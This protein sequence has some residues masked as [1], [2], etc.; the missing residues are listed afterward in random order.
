[1]LKN[2]NQRIAIVLAVLSAFYLILSYQLPTYPYIPVDADAIPKTLGWLLLALSVG[3]FFSKDR[4]S[5]EQKAKRHI[6]K[7]DVISLLV[8]FLFVFLYITFF[9]SLGFILAT[10]LFV[11]SSTWYLGY[12]KHLVNA[13]VSILFPVILYSIFVYMLQ[14]RLPAGILPF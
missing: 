2:V 11:F 13:I 1:M 5:E 14:I 10:V 12:K 8:V 6:P 7:K 4:D 3:L 9:E